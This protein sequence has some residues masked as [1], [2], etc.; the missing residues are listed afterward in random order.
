MLLTNSWYRAVFALFSMLGLTNASL[1]ARLPEV[2]ESV[3]TTTAGIGFILLGFAIG[4]LGGLTIAG[5]LIERVGARPI[6]TWGFVGMGVAALG[7]ALTVF[8]G[9]D[10]GLFIAFVASGLVGSAVDVAL[11]VN[12]ADLEQR[13]GKTVMPSLHAGFSIGTFVGVGIGVV[14]TASELSLPL[15]VTVLA[16]V[17]S[18]VA[19]WLVRDIDV[20][21]HRPEERAEK[22]VST[23]VWTRPAVVAL[24]A[25]IFAMTLA[26]GASNDWLVLALVDD[27]GESRTNGAIAYACLMVAMIITRIIGGR[28][29]DRLG[30]ARTLQLFAAIG[31]VG[32]VTVILSGNLW[33]A[34]LGSAL[35]GAGVALGFPL[36]LSAAGERENPARTVSFV[37]STGYM[38]FLVGPPVLGLV[39]QSIGLL[40]MFWILVAAILASALF[41][42]SADGRPSDQ[43]ATPKLVE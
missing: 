10:V 31:A 24:G 25:G 38:A 12:G 27:Y 30:R 36:F 7:Q 28:I 19:V 35:W 9:T 20:S 29:S 32:I 21:A 39:A 40:T 18:A 5:R 17:T 1:L 42:R 15:Q 22:G 41:A 8:A 14:G 11:N 43:S 26:E 34:Y 3:H 6:T 13:L 2:R 16:V 23:P 4:S 33:L 37:A